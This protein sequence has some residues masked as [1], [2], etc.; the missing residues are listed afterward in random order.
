MNKLHKESMKKWKLTAGGAAAA[1]LCIREISREMQLGLMMG[2]GL[3]KAADGGS[4]GSTCSLQ[5]GG[6]SN[7]APEKSV[8]FHW[9]FVGELDVGQHT[10]TSIGAMDDQQGADDQFILVI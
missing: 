2:R 5:P 6:G 3:L 4:A 1:N 7:N 10:Y 8:G 9:N